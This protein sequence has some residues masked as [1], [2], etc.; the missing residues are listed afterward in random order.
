M[1]MT[2]GEL[3]AKLIDLE[4]EEG[5]RPVALEVGGD[6]AVHR[7]EDIYVEIIDE[8]VVLTSEEPP[9]HELAEEES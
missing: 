7:S 2:L 4:I 5:F 1:K 3:I 6:G 9:H 8:H